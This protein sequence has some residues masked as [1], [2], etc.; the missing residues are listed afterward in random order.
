MAVSREYREYVL[1]QMGRV[2]PVTAQ[3]MFGG[4]GIRSEGVFFALISGDAVYLKTDDTNRPDF[5]AAGM[6]PFDPY[7]DGR[8]MLS[9]HELPAEMLEDPDVLRPWLQN[10][11]DVARRKR[12]PAPRKPRRG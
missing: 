6:A 9:Y 10:A 12:K 2:L 7:Q 11:L 8:V 1:E 5:E 4:V 3:S